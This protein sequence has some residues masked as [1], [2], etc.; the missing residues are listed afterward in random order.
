MKICVLTCGENF[1]F[2]ETEL[3]FLE[4]YFYPIIVLKK[5]IMCHKCKE[6]I[7]NNRWKVINII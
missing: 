6:L 3:E 4:R 1:F 5:K 2:W 7:I